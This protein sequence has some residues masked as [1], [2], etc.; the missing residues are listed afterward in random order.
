MSAVAG[1]RPSPRAAAPPAAGA[2]TY[3]GLVTRAIA[4]AV[5]AAILNGVAI[6]V[7]AGVTLVLS[8]VSVSGDLEAWI[9]AA[10]GAAYLLWSV[11]YFATFWSTT[12]QTPGN[13]LMRI[14]VVAAS[15][16]AIRPRRAV[17]RF[18]ALA[19]G[20]AAL[21]AG[22]W[23]ILIDERRRALHDFVARTV[24]VDERQAGRV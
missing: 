14:R 20:A 1:S 8:V 3:I 7:A 11:G 5:D 15:G 19:V 18:A 9:A 24:V 4:F 13:R 21:L 12:G 2:P 6:V 23:L 17:L 10:G 22:I 16:D